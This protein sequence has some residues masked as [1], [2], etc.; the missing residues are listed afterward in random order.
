[1]KKQQTP[2]D[3]ISDDASQGWIFNEIMDQMNACIYVTDIETDEILFMNKTMKKV[4]NLENPEGKICW[5]LLQT[6]MT[7]RCDFC[8]VSLLLSD[9]ESPSCIWEETNTL[10]GRVY[11]NFDSLMHW[12][13]GRLVHFQHST[14]ITETK[15]LSAAARTDE[16]TG[17]LN[18][19]AGKE[20]L[21]QIL[22]TCQV[23]KN[24]LF[25]ICM[26]DVNDLKQINDTYGHTSGDRLL[27]NVT[28]A[29]QSRLRP[30]D[31]LFRLSGDEFVV[32]FHSLLL[33][34][35]K[36]II[37]TVLEDL[38]QLHQYYLTFRTSDF[39]FGLIE[40]TE[41]C[42]FSTEELLSAVDEKLYLQKR[43]FHIEKAEQMRKQKQAA[44]P[45]T[46]LDDFSYNEDL[47]Y[48]A[49]IQSTDDYIYI[50][51]MK[52]GV[53]RYPQTMVDE[54]DL[55]GQIIQNAAAVWGAKVHPHDKQAFL[56]SN[57]DITDGHTAAH[58]VEYR[59]KNRRGEWVWL[60]C[61]GHLQYDQDGEPA[62]FAGFITNL[63]KKNNIDPLT[64][65]FNKFEFEAEIER[66]LTYPDP[67][68]TLLLLGMDNLKHI[69]NLY[70]HSFGDEVIRIT[71]QKIR[72]LIPSTAS[73]YRLDG[74]EF[75]VLLQETEKDNIILLYQ[76]LRFAFNHQQFYDSKKFFCT[77][78]CG[79]VLAPQDGID[80]LGL[81]KH[82]NYALD[83][84]KHNGK[85]QLCFF[86]RELLTHK[87]RSLELISLL[88]ESAENHWSDFSL[89]YQPVFS[90][91]RRLAGAEALVRWHCDKYGPLSPTEFIPLLEECGLILSAGRWIFREAVKQ[92]AQWL[93]YQKDF[94]IGINLSYLQLEDPSLFDFIVETLDEFQVP[95]EQIIL[96]LTESYLASNMRQLRRLLTRLR[97][98][99]LRVAMDDFG[100]GYSSLA[101]LKQAP[102]DIV[103]IDRTFVQ[104][105]QNNTFDHHFIHLIIELCHTIS[106][107][108]CLE[109]VETED[110]Y[111]VISSMEPDYLQGFLFGHPL[112]PSQ[113][114]RDFFFEQYKQ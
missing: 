98:T 73:L 54:F 74:D 80:F 32:V 114:Q 29:I 52:T 111:A 38:K 1:M 28:K 108:T 106:L 17:I 21:Q 85:N 59:A 70:D 71:S 78:S 47:F 3:K 33:K 9:D 92:C 10:N 94:L 62:L 53:F 34:E 68:F 15:R 72:S 113:F 2:K 40:I 18:R 49:L 11:E 100:T 79:C 31:V 95:P 63:G 7:H 89:H 36:K 22:H 61:R 51:N 20:I 4:F 19:R 88:R 87:K 44:L 83:Y 23:Q 110:E 43:R 109:G 30:E 6:N 76:N 14:D 102:V 42:P 101:I 56:E 35:A 91:Q 27:V 57:Q 58:C 50:C 96:E 112:P 16:L 48:D 69:N 39:C 82:A 93:K 26:L 37:E 97:N 86:T 5:K 41:G 103:K 84:A 13:D 105:I 8:P 25:S 81:I 65:L 60:R 67:K 45:P 75:A 99:K 55:P 46:G 90:P 66:L 12:L 104:N 24:S 77:L 64:G 107:K